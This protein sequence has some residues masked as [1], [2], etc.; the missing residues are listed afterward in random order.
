M[1]SYLKETFKDFNNYKLITN[2]VC[3][4]NLPEEINAISVAT[5]DVDLYE[6]TFEEIKKFLKNYQIEV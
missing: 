1:K 2:N 6:A 4:D 5:I 3:K